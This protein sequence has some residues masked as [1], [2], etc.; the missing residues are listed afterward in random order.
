MTDAAFTSLSERV[1]P[2]AA[3]AH[4][5]AIAWLA[6]PPA[7]ALGD[8]TALARR[9]GEETRVT[10]IRTPASWPR[11]A[12]APASSPAAMT[13]ASSAAAP[14]AER[15]RSA[16]AAG[17]WIDAV[18]L[19]PGGAIA[20]SAG[21]I[22]HARDD[23]GAR[24]DARARPRPRA[25]SPSRR[26]ATAWPSSHYNGVSLWFPNAER[27]ARIPRMEGLPSS[28][29]R[30]RRTGASSSPRC[31]RTRCMAGA[32]P[33]SSTC[34]CPAIPPR[35]A[36][37]P[38]R[39]TATG[40]PP[41]APTPPSSGPSRPRTGR[42]ARRRANAASAPPRSPA[43]P[44]TPRRSCWPSATRT[45]ACCCAGS[46]TPPSFWCAAPADGSAITALAWDASGAQLAFGAEDG[47]AG[48]LTLPAG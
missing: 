37:C 21:K 4:V 27:G 44:S 6:A 9:D 42:W 16:R 19:G 17:K 31:R 36:R 5:V 8:G 38:G 1:A 13:A 33:T 11:P 40:S 20:W 29:S 47:A 22:V 25:A 45:A 23:K 26:R 39:M 43:S 46:P 32:S 24:E 2:I 15:A 34:A 48:I 30:C 3:G 12:T 18:A 35:R 28:T 10:R 7:F 41:P 14:T